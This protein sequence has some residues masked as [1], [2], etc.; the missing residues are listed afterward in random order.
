MKKD[1]YKDKTILITGATGS[2]GKSFLRYLAENTQAKKLIVFSR[3]EFKQF[4]MRQEFIDYDDKIRY[5]LGDIRDKDRMER[6]FRGVDI[7]VHAAALKHVPMLEYNPYEAVK[8]NILG[9]QNV[10]EAAIDSGVERVLL[11]STDK[12]AEPA[13]LY[14]STKLCA[15]KLCVSG[16]SYSDGGT[17]FSCVRY[18]NVVGSRGSIVEHLLLNDDIE[19]VQVTDKD[20]TRFW[21]TLP[22]SFDLVT[23]ALSNMRGGEVFIPKI[24]SLKIVDMF[25]ALVPN[26]KKNFVGIRPGEKLHEVLLT[27]EEARHTLDLGGYFVIL[28]ESEE[29]FDI[30]TLYSDYKKNGKKLSDEYSYTSD[31]NTEWLAKEDFKK[32]A[33]EKKKLYGM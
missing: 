1:I 3:D 32:M 25:D 2:F 4:H 15:E 33:E 6:A 5:F 12:A 9:T 11:I 19:E 10:I 31:S 21:I 27:K 7:V 8:T 22:Q 28:P 30:D 23:Y 18:G 13:N 26:A 16:N 14:G 24:P 17:I 20:M 29:I